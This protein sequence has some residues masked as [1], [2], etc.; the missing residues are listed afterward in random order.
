M[1]SS[2]T[3]LS[4]YPPRGNQ[5]I[6]VAAMHQV[7]YT[8]HLGA[9]WGPRGAVRMIHLSVDT[10]CRCHQPMSQLWANSNDWRG[11]GH[12]QVHRN[13]MNTQQQNNIPDRSGPGPTT[14]G[15]S[16]GTLQLGGD[17]CATGVRS[18]PRAG[19][20]TCREN[21]HRTPYMLAEK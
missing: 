2:K 14:T 8:R 19:I 6:L 10:L 3:R 20:T 21:Y 5:W 1:A 18:R 16:T 15:P 9:A 11:D 17:N 7:N 12:H 13:A 4:S